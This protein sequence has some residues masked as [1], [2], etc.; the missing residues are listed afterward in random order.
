MHSRVSEM[1]RA[2]REFDGKTYARLHLGYICIYRLG[3]RERY[4]LAGSC[5]ILDIIT[6]HLLR[7]NTYFNWDYE[8]LPTRC[9]NHAGLF[10]ILHCPRDIPW[11]SLR[12]FLAFSLSLCLA[13]PVYDS[14]R[15]SKYDDT[16]ESLTRILG[17]KRKYAHRFL[18][19]DLRGAK[20]VARQILSAH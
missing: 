9:T 11:I 20:A 15:T 3:Y 5:L 16:R 8:Q 4:L 6:R 19:C 14:V 7:H 18:D 12:I 2:W 1:T 10:E 17:T 13:A